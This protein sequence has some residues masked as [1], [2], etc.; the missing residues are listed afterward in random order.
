MVFINRKPLEVN[1]AEIIDGNDFYFYFT[2]TKFGGFQ[3]N[4]PKHLIF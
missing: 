4:Q 1:R 3:Y 2:L